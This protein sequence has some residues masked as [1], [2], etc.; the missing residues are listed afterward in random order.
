M[1]DKIWIEGVCTAA[2][3]QIKSH[4]VILETAYATPQLANFAINLIDY[5]L[6]KSNKKGVSKHA[7]KVLKK[8]GR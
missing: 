4:P 6:L 5:A 3:D 8:M 2:C 7:Q 1:T